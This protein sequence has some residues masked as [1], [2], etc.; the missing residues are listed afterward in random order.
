MENVISFSTKRRAYCQSPMVSSHSATSCV[1]EL[2]RAAALGAS[3]GFGFNTLLGRVALDCLLPGALER[4]FMASTANRG[5]TIIS[6]QSS[7]GHG[8]SLRPN[9]QEPPGQLPSA[10]HP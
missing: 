3:F 9:V 4:F 8:A 5:Q 2:R 6:G 10:I 7:T 1:A